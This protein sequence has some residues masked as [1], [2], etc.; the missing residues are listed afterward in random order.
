LVKIKL[1]IKLKKAETYKLQAKAIF[2][3]K[4]ILLVVAF[5][6]FSLG[7][8]PTKVNLQE[9]EGKQ[10][11][12]ANGGGFT[13][14]VIEYTLLENGYVYKFNSLTNANSFHKRIEKDDANQIFNNYE[15]LNITELKLNDPG[16]MYFYI[17]MDHKDKSQQ[18]KW[19]T[20]SKGKEADKA[21]LFYMT[22]LQRLK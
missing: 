11:T 20:E 15:L 10:L 13:G 16:N 7:C 1:K 17:R 9:Y 22:V 19:N 21:K 14:Q 4:A 18:I 3:M 5:F 6:T 2:I 8:K 12:V